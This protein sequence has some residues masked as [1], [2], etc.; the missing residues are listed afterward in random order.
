M[1]FMQDYTDTTQAMCRYVFRAMSNTMQATKK[2][3]TISG[4]LHPAPGAVR[5]KHGH[6]NTHTNEDVKH[7]PVTDYSHFMCPKTGSMENCI[8]HLLRLLLPCLAAHQ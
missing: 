6:Q 2:A 4:G 3:H 7:V 1:P 8:V 5:R